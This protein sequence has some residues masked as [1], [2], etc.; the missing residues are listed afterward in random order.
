MGA[1]KCFRAC[2]QLF[3]ALVALVVPVAPLRT[4]VGFGGL[5]NDATAG[6]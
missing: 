4:A 3:L 6:G 2:V 5:F 1:E